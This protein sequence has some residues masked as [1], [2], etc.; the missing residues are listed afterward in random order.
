[1]IEILN[2]LRDAGRPGNA[3][4]RIEFAVERFIVLIEPIAN[5]NFNNAVVG[6]DVRNRTAL[7]HARI[8]GRA[9]LDVGEPGGRERKAHGS[10]VRV[11]AILRIVAGMCGNTL[12]FDPVGRHALARAHKLAAS[13]GGFKD[14]DI[15]CAL[16]VFAKPGRRSLGADFFIRVE[17]AAD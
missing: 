13:A 10:E 5:V 1:M 14:E 17:G 11:G 7:D 12:E 8:N 4:K 2:R 9:E 3:G 16:A 15:L 6:N